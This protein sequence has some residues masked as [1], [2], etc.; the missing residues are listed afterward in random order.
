M[1]LSEILKEENSF[2]DE[3]G[4]LVTINGPL[5]KIRNPSGDTSYWVN[6]RLV[7]DY[8]VSRH[9]PGTY[10]WF[11]EPEEIGEPE[12][13]ISKKMSGKH[14]VSF[15]KPNIVSKEVFDKMLRLELEDENL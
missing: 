1:R 7:G 6:N 10:Y 14:K 2:N 9:G 4:R 12:Q 3:H 11:S 8:E 5:K 15:H 13:M